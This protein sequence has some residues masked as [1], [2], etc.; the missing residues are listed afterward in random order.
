MVRSPHSRAR[1]QGACGMTG[2]HENALTPASLATDGN[3][4]ENANA[5]SVGR[6]EHS[7]EAVALPLALFYTDAAR[8]TLRRLAILTD[9]P[10]PGTVEAA[11]L[12][13][14]ARDLLAQAVAP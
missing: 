4:G 2:P 5:G 6:A 10:P 9:H 12:L 11:D 14:A 1:R 3:Q 13:D 7:A 8:D